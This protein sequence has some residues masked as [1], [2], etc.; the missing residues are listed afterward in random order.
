MS[1]S[2]KNPKEDQRMNSMTPQYDTMLFCDVWDD[3]EGF[4]TDYKSSGL[5]SNVN[6][7]SDA[8]AS[9]LFYLLYAKYGNN[10]IANRDVNQ[11]QYKVFSII[12]EYGPTWEKELSI[13][14]SLRDMTTADIQKGSFAM[15]NQALNTQNEPA[16]DT[17][18]PLKFINS[19]NTTRYT[20]SPLDGYAMLESLLSADVTKAF[21]DRFKVCFKTFV[22]PENPLLYVTDT[23]DEEND[24][25]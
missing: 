4:V 15:Y 25:D 12:F 20:K 22:R 24:A 3:A 11:F 9:T 17:T 2:P 8:S 18:D 10:P 23:E 7:I 13:Q 19:Q 6:K 1:L 21:I 5:Y 16:A 14:K